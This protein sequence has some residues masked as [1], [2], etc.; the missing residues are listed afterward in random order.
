MHAKVL[1]TLRQGVLDPAG[2]AVATSLNQL[3]FS[4]VKGVRIGK[5]LEVELDDMPEDEA[6]KHLEEMGRQLL[7][8]TVIEDFEVEF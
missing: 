1:V 7:A 8:N 2:Q 6:R 4:Q 5:V 3:G